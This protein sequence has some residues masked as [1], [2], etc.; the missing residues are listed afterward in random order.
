MNVPLAELSDVRKVYGSGA[1]EVTALGGVSLAVEAGELVAIMGASGSGK[2][3]LLAITGTLETPTA[4]TVRISGLDAGAM[5]P[6]QRARLRRRA[7][8][9]V[10]Q[11]FNLVPTLTAVENVA[12]PLELD[13]IPLREARR[14]AADSLGW[15]GLAGLEGRYPDD[16]SG[17]QR[18]RVAIAR[19]TVGPRELILADEPTGALD[20]D[21]G[22][23]V[24]TMLRRRIDEGAGG[25]L[26][27]HDARYAAWA[28]RVVFLKD[29][30]IVDESR[31]EPVSM[32]A[33]DASARLEPS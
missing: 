30:R 3:T 5:T 23:V 29:G 21:T 12:L 7:L 20:S 11:D 18:Q 25:L 14:A 26:V 16:L 1:A 31:P 19:A 4:G 33:L 6:R 32:D 2:S 17:G 10:F 22:E 15:V 13:G 27:T 24:L 28:D 9:F 8:G